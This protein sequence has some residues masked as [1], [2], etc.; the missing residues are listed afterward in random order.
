VNIFRLTGL[1]KLPIATA[2]LAVLPLLAVFTANAQKPQGSGNVP[3]QAQTMDTAAPSMPQQVGEDEAKALR[4]V[5]GA[6]SAKN[7]TQAARDRSAANIGTALDNAKTATLNLNNAIANVAVVTG[8]S[9]KSKSR[10]SAEIKAEKDVIDARDAAEKSSESADRQ[11]L[12]A[13]NRKA[14]DQ[15][16]LLSTTNQ[17]NHSK[18]D[19]A[20]IQAR[21]LLAV[22][23]GPLTNQQKIYNYRSALKIVPCPG[24]VD[25]V[26]AAFPSRERPFD[27]EIVMNAQT[28]KIFWFDPSLRSNQYREVSRDSFLPSVSTKE[29]VLKAVCGLHFG[30]KANITASTVA[31]PDI[32]PILYSAPAF[33][34]GTVSLSKAGTIGADVMSP[35]NL[36]LLLTASPCEPELSNAIAALTDADRKFHSADATFQ[37]SKD[38]RVL[39]SLDNG[40]FSVQHLVSD[41]D[42]ARETESSQFNGSPTPLTLSNVTVFNRAI[43]L[44]NYAGSDLT[45]LAAKVS[46]VLSGTSWKNFR[47]AADDLTTAIQTYQ[48]TLKNAKPLTC[49]GMAQKVAEA[50]LEAEDATKA[51]EQAFRAS[52]HIVNTLMEKNDQLTELY[53]SINTDYSVS[54]VTDRYLPIFNPGNAL[55]FLSFNVTD[56]WKPYGAP[57]PLDISTDT[58]VKDP[59]DSAPAP[60]PAPSTA[61]VTVSASDK[62]T[63]VTVVLPNAPSATATAIAT[64]SGSSPAPGNS[65][66]GSGGDLQPDAKVGLWQKF[67]VHFVATGG[68]MAQEGHSHGYGVEALTTSV[69][70]TTST[71]YTPVG[72]A[73]FL[74]VTSAITP[75]TESFAYVTDNE[76]WH[77]GALLGLTYFPYSRDTFGNRLQRKDGHMRLWDRPRGPFY[78]DLG[79]FLGTTVNTAGTFVGALS[80]EVV[81]GVEMYAGLS[82]FS[83]NKLS[84]GIIPC[85][86]LSL[87]GST[88]NAPPNILPTQK[89]P[90]GTLINT[91]IQV[92]T[93]ST[94]GNSNATPITGTTAPTSTT[95]AFA[96]A[97][98]ILLNSNLFKALGIG[99]S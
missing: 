90:T 15:D 72:S 27:P 58:P 92:S 89:D 39:R 67:I 19:L 55:T 48:D 35:R 25:P 11:L 18:E 47:K 64:S 87:G 54:S 59:V 60:K 29:K 61:T 10:T 45:D 13:L 6:E 80:Y 37:Q 41:L 88:Y 34:P 50:N 14:S 36:N 46:T 76:N 44:T 63:T 31:L 26:G 51:I 2:C 62:P 75:G 78:K 43:T 84:T 79:F 22:T 97:F 91:T 23:S 66:S 94:C 28:G 52:N 93:S 49:R 38:Y 1:S 69:L 96:P 20:D 85:N 73:P 65:S 24:Q 77:F 33:D 81:P 21:K 30:A 82:N 57:K 68:L 16:A 56:S 95:G 42:A 9:T 4:D 71:T 40:P 74:T 70:T 8:T 53:A 7:S 3:A 32:S 99:K 5:A 12:D 17:L 83:T 98:G 86:S